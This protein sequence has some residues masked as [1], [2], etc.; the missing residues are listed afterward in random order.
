MKPKSLLAVALTLLLAMTI[1][2]ATAN[3]GKGNGASKAPENPGKPIEVV[4]AIQ[5]RKDAVAEAKDAAKEAKDATQEALAATNDA[6]KANE[7]AQAKKEAGAPDAPEAQ[8][9]A[10]E[11][12]DKADKVRQ[13]AVE[14]RREAASLSADAKNKAAVAL[15]KVVENLVAKN[16]IKAASAVG[17]ALD[18]IQGALDEDCVEFVAEKKASDAAACA[19]ANY[20]VR[21]SNGVDAGTEAKNLAASKITFTKTFSKAFS[22]GVAKLNAKQLAA[23]ASSTKVQSIE[24]DFEVNVTSTQT[25]ATWGL[26]RVDQAALPLSTTYTNAQSGSGVVVYVV[27]TGVNATHVDFGGRVTSGYSVISD[28]Q[29]S[30]DCNGHGTHVA[31]TI[32]GSTYGIAKAVTVVPVRVLDCAGS[33]L[34]S[35]VVAGLDWIGANYT[36]GTKAVVNMSLGGGASSTLDSAVSSLIAKGITV[37]VAAGNSA[38]DACNFS[39]A[40][41][42]GAITVAASTITD[43]IASYSNFGSCVDIVA[44]GSGVVS[45]WIGSATAIATLNGTSMASPHVAGLAAS[46]M[47]SGY[48]TPFEAESKLEAVAA[49]NVIAGLSSTTPNL[50][51]QVVVVAETPTTSP[52]VS[53]TV[54]VAPGSVAATAVRNSATVTWVA[55]ADGGSALTK[56]TVRIWQNG[57]LVK[58]I[59]VTGSATSATIG[60]LKQNQTYTFT[61]IATNLIGNSAESAASNPVTIRR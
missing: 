2:P 24:Q 14:A 51:A 6:V 53:A 1:A 8:Q 32:A 59:E 47:S 7:N 20:V 37:V 52:T 30:L 17:K 18:K 58:R 61:V 12:Q 28:G 4:E 34:L 39:P 33:G 43:S 60:G 42:P 45:T 26:D 5:E 16:N 23:L 57:R 19:T 49:K 27:D 50:L 41:V 35:G 40:R 11:A 21:F 15:E 9:K 48:L 29:G 31:G 56:N 22:G 55:S 3:P 46:V 25:D 54:P 13:E 44:P 10:K 38:A 36:P